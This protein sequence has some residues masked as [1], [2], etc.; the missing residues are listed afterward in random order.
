MAQERRITPA[1]P[2]LNPVGQ[3][4]DYTLLEEIARGGM[5]AI[6]RARDNRLDRIVALKMVLGE[7]LH[8]PSER[9]RFKSEVE[10]VARLE[11]P[12][13]VPLYDV[14][15][16]H[17]RP[18]FTMK[19][20]ESG[21]L[22]QRR[23]DL[24]LPR[25]DKARKD[26]SGTTWS[27]HSLRN[28]QQRIAQLM[29]R[30]A[31]AVHFAHQRGLLHRDLKPANILLDGD[32]PVVTDFGIAKRLDQKSHITLTGA[33]LGTPAYMAPEQAEGRSDLTTA[34]DVFSLGAILYDLL[35]GQPP[36]LGDTPMQTLGKVLLTEAQPA[37][38]RNPCVDHD[39]N[40]ICQKCLQRDPLRRYGSAGELA[41]D[42]QRWTDGE[43][44][45]AR[46]VTIAERALKWMKRRPVL[47]T[48]TAFTALTLLAVAVTLA[49][50]LP[51]VLTA[52]RDER[53]A[54][55]LAEQRRQQAENAL[56]LA[57][58]R[59]QAALQAARSEQQARAR[60][61]QR[62]D[63][64]AEVAVSYMDG[65]ETI[66]SLP[67]A[68]PARRTFSANAVS[69][70]NSLATTDRLFPPN[71]LFRLSRAYMIAA[72]VNQSLHLHEQA[73]TLLIE[74]TQQLD[75]LS[76]HLARTPEDA[77]TLLK[78]SVES[79]RAT[80]YAS[81][82][83]L[84]R[85]MGDEDAAEQA[86]QQHAEAT[87]RL[88]RLDPEAPVYLHHKATQLARQARN[89]ATGSSERLSRLQ[90]ALQ[91]VQNISPD[92]EDAN[93]FELQ[94]IWLLSEIADLVD[95]EEGQIT[96]AL[97]L[98]RDAAS[99]IER[100]LELEPHNIDLHIEATYIYAG[101]GDLAKRIGQPELALEAAQRF[102][103]LATL[104]SS[105]D[106]DRPA[107]EYALF[108]AQR[109]LAAAIAEQQ[110]Q[111]AEHL[112]RQAV[113]GYHRLIQQGVD[114][115]NRI[116]SAIAANL[117]LA[118]L[119]ARRNQRDESIQILQNAFPILDHAEGQFGPLVTLRIS[120][121]NLLRTLAV[122]HIRHA[123]P[124]DART[125]LSLAA[126]LAS[127]LLEDLGS[128]PL[129]QAVQL[130]EHTARLARAFQDADAPE[131]GIRI[132]R[133]VT[134]AIERILPHARSAQL[135]AALLTAR[136]NTTRLLEVRSKYPEMLMQSQKHV[137]HI[138]ELLA[139]YP[140]AIQLHA[141]A[142][143][144][145]LD[146][147]RAAWRCAMKPHGD[148]R[149]LLLLEAQAAS[150]AADDLWNS[151]QPR[152]SDL[153]NKPDILADERVVERH[154]DLQLIRQSLHALEAPHPSSPVVV[155]K[156]VTNNTNAQRLGM[157]PLDIVRTY[158]GSPIHTTNDFLRI[159]RARTPGQQNAELTL[160]RDG[161]LLT[162]DV[163]PGRIGFALA[164]VLHPQ[165]P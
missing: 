133:H 100:L 121:I 153:P 116:E 1:S 68:G 6:Y 65:Y 42:L 28:R 105:A 15:E 92:T 5:G 119:L 162:C 89:L 107:L 125:Q 7:H 43:P 120:R 14:G 71:F 155:I 159:H 58:Q 76:D 33:V 148:D 165:S 24:E 16:V 9:E 64:L 128:T 160:E 50:L 134:D 19:L 117:E 146:H 131:G 57:E 10:A 77:F 161:A 142:L 23:P 156:I 164:M 103:Q 97:S 40:V 144:I 115:H 129:P 104:A 60:E 41:D 80:A 46:P 8:N 139:A 61:E 45:L 154:I 111:Q 79:H 35:T 94:R 31:R 106:P 27:T 118:E 163:P 73:R 88:A 110:P 143:A 13:I 37:T 124:Q 96:Q 108:A 151:I 135:A 91:L 126:E 87:A 51:M 59:E 113:D 147:A 69:L 158:N 52:N 53:S 149:R 26:P 85:R 93:R 74:A 137:Q 3:F 30:I 99:R 20:V 48:A 22:A 67:G 11:H 2:P 95:T 25:V 78:P 138:P 102:V 86:I 39:L 63:Q 123:R 54:R 75:K 127:A 81:L 34:A 90:Q 49:I 136:L 140:T 56:Q 55:E 44:I 17:G 157:K 62:F 4:G 12:N 21:N 109:H 112:V 130:I 66:R 101:V 150:L 114:G 98:Y 38:S 141:I 122:H 82:A 70:L 84:A 29:I 47:A 145:H 18:F 32:E 152:L 83:A 132:L 72:E 36:F